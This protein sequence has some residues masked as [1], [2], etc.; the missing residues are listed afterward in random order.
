M[1]KIIAVSL[2]GLNLLVGAEAMTKEWVVT[3][4]NFEEE[5][6][7][8]EVDFKNQAGVYKAEEKF[9]PCLR[10]SLNSKKEVKVDFDPMK[11]TIK[12]CS[13]AATR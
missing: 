5:K 11:M 3:R 7:L 13:M 6:K 8:Y 1:K 12:S 2:M 4:V 10:E 9:L